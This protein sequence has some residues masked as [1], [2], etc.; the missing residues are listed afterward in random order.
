MDA[1][2]YECMYESMNKCVCVYVY[3][4]VFLCMSVSVSVSCGQITS[5][6]YIIFLCSYAYDSDDTLSYI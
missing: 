6:N 2:V 4:R 5:A 1:Y 3:V